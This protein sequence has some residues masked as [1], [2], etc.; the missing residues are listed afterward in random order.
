MPR[1]IE[2][3]LKL[4]DPDRLRAVLR[5][6][7]ATYRGRDFEI[8]RIFDFPDGRLRQ[9]GNALRVRVTR[10]LINAGKSTGT[11]TFKGPRDAA[12]LKSREEIEMS[13][14]DPTTLVIILARLG[15][16]Q[17]VRYEKRRE[18]WSLR[19]CEI[20][21]DELPQLGWYVEIEG[22]NSESVLAVRDELELGKVPAEDDSYVQLAIT[23]GELLDG[24]HTL[25]FGG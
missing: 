5:D 17:R 21:L 23:H 7:G 24:V 12:A 9:G 6:H 19:N 10:P 16:V 18:T 1:E 22:P 14:D 15:L 13:V 25:G 2:I 3:K 8:N 20:V 4:E 11:L